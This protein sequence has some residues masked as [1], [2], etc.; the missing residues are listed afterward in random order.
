LL[1]K[2]WATQEPVKRS[3]NCDM[4]SAHYETLLSQVGDAV[5]AIKQK[6]PDQPMGADLNNDQL[7]EARR[8]QIAIMRAQAHEAG[9]LAQR[10]VEAGEVE[11]A[12]VLSEWNDQMGHAADEQARYMASSEFKQWLADRMEWLGV[13][14]VA[15]Q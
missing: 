8:A 14:A 7:V 10:N 5:R 3:E 4:S 6:H 1:T 12:R 2:Y 11:L 15:G 13:P 9:V